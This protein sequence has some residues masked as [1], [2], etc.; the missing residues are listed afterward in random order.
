MTQIFQ[1]VAAEAPQLVDHTN[2]ALYGWSLA[3]SLFAILFGLAA[4][5][6]C[7]FTG[8]LKKWPA[9]ISTVAVLSLAIVGFNYGGHGIDSE[10]DSTR[11]NIAQAIESKYGVKAL[12][13]RHVYHTSELNATPDSINYSAIP[14]T[15][16]EGQRIQ[17]T[18]EF[19]ENG[20]DVIAFS[21]GAE[22]QK[23]KG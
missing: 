14:A 11:S 15:N 23:I 12:D 9:I 4:I 19:A 7:I 21:S 2:A 3:L 20:T 1:I 16:P 22:I 10:R 13:P 6:Y 17:I 5:F 18:I 8:K